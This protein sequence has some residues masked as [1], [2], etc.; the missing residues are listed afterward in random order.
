MGYTIELRILPSCSMKSLVTNQLRQQANQTGVGYCY[1]W[2]N[3]QNEIVYA[4]CYDF[5][6]KIKHFVK[7]LMDF[8]KE[9]IVECMYH[10]MPFRLFY[11]HTPGQKQSSQWNEYERQLVQSLPKK[12]KNKSKRGHYQ[13]NHIRAHCAIFKQELIAKVMH[14]LRIARLLEEYGWEAM[15]VY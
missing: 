4:Y 14:P 5:I 1:E 2:E 3:E 8:R 7:A 11:S 9:I 15:E 12:N 13:Y 6:E 10:E